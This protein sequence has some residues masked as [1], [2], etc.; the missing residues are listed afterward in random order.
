MRVLVLD[1]DQA[2]NKKVESVFSSIPDHSLKFFA[3]IADLLEVLNGNP[4]IEKRKVELEKNIIE[5]ET[6]LKK[7]KD[8]V[9]HTD[10]GIKEKREQ[11]DFLIKNP[12]PNVQ[13]DTVEKEL[14]ALEIQNQKAKELQ[15][16]LEAILQKKQA[17]VAALTS[18]VP[19]EKERKIDLILADRSFL[20]NTPK[21]WVDDFRS[22]IAL[23]ENQEVP[24]VLMG[25]NEDL[26]YIV[27]TLQSGADDYFIKPVDSLL[28][29]HNSLRIAGKR[30]ESED[31]IF[32]MQSK[33]QMKL[34]RV[35]QVQKMSEFEVQVQTST[36]FQAKEFVEFYTDFFQVGKGGRL[37]GRVLSCEADTS[38]K[39]QYLTRFSF[40]GLSQHI[41]NELRKWL[42]TQYVTAKKLE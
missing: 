4:S 19:T 8:T 1:V 37:L 27:S 2:H 32:E 34:L 29:K 22:K 26:D 21:G 18:S 41:M 38:Q 39:G 14:R 3:S 16:K 23:K 6:L 11:I 40:V 33:S 35:V 12:D 13:K 31:K 42:R 7:V 10:Q 20:G 9:V 28:L 15:A 36:V 30:L 17:D 5:S 24:L 25:Y